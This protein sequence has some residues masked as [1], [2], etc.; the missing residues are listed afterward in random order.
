MMELRSG[1][2]LAISW[3]PEEHVVCEKYERIFGNKPALIAAGIK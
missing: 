3:I 2:S 1:E